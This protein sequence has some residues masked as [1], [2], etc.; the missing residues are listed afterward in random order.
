MGMNGT[1]RS[2]RRAR[3][4]ALL[5]AVP[6]TL[7]AAPGLAFADTTAVAVDG[8]ALRITGFSGTPS[9]VE[10]RHRSAEE[11][12]FGDVGD[13]YEVTDEGGLQAS[14]QGCAQ[15]SATLASCDARA[16]NS[17]LA[18]LGDGG[19]VL[20]LDGTQAAGVP[21]DVPAL[22]N[23]QKGADGLRGGPGRDRIRG[24][25]GRDTIAG[26]AGDDILYGG[27]GADGL[28]GF[29][30]NDRLYGGSGRDALFA[31]KG[32]DRLFGGTENDV[33]LARDGFK[34]PVISCGKGGRQTATTDSLDP[35]PRGC[36]SPKQ[37]KRQRGKE[38]K[39]LRAARPLAS[40]AAGLAQG[41]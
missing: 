36:T 9:A 6:A 14:G 41:L 27:S 25:P 34:D 23:G 12:G 10:V 29:A 22:L 11:A 5:V 4:G 1:H 3:L 13:R 19:D 28:I 39:R 24:G 2:S 33:L 20:V 17:M 21:A 18:T 26:W 7:S 40:P 35:K 32:R 37:R 16:V 8:A 31:Q 15:V 38:K 30:G